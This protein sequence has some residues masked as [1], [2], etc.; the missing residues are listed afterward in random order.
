MASKKSYEDEKGNKYGAWK[1][2]RKCV[3]KNGT[4]KWVQLG[5]K[6]E[7]TCFN[8]K[9]DG[10]LENQWKLS[11]SLKKPGQSQFTAGDKRSGIIIKS[12]ELANKCHFEQGDATNIS[13]DLGTFDVV[14]AANLLCRLPRP[15]D[16][17]NRLPTLIN[18][19]GLLV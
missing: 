1:L 9:N 14:L 6:G 8:E 19:N 15:M 16:F 11:R 4:V 3:K 2:Y 5:T 13:Y 17:I 12:E 7:K 18:D 10:K